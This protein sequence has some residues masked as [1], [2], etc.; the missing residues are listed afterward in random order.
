MSVILIVGLRAE[1]GEEGRAEGGE[2][3]RPWRWQPRMRP[4]EGDG[5][6]VDAVVEADEGAVRCGA[7][8]EA[9]VHF[10][11]ADSRAGDEVR[12]GDG[13][14]LFVAGHGGGDV[15]QAEAAS[16]VLVAFDSLRSST[17]LPSI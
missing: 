13:A 6:V 11:A 12:A 5:A 2:W 7:G 4:S 3:K 15:E 8:G 9:E 16:G 1:A 14:E 10:V 17:T